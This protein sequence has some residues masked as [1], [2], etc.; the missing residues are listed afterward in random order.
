[1]SPPL[2]QGPRRRS[3]VRRHC[4]RKRAIQQ[5]LRFSGCTGRFAFAA[6]DDRAGGYSFNGVGLSAGGSTPNDLA[7]MQVIEKLPVEATSATRL[8]RPMVFSAAA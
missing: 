2:L 3:T 1:M 5:P 4:P 7:V 8:S 6:Q